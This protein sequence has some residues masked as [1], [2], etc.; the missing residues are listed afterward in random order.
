MVWDGS[1]SACGLFNGFWSFQND[2][3]TILSL[4]YSFNFYL[5]SYE[6]YWASFHVLRPICIFLSVNFFFHILCPFLC[7]VVVDGL[8]KLTFLALYDM[9]SKCITQLSFGAPLPNNCITRCINFLCLNYLAWFLFLFSWS[10]LDW[11]IWVFFFNSLYKIIDE[12]T[13]GSI[14]R[15]RPHCLFR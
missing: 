3:W 10:D 8:Y 7:G 4:H 6:W 1:K 15:Q 11:Y 14:T 9:N 2:K 13:S 5:F 12:K